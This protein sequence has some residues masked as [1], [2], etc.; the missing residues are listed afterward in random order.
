MPNSR[1][2]INAGVWHLGV[3]LVLL[4][5]GHC[6]AAVIHAAGMDDPKGQAVWLSA[7][8]WLT[9]TWLL[10]LIPDGSGARSYE[11]WRLQT[12]VQF[13][14]AFASTTIILLMGGALPQRIWAFGQRSAILVGLILGLLLGGFW[15]LVTSE[16][17]PMLLLLA[18]LGAI[19]SGVMHARCFGCRLCV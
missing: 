9:P 12:L 10:D 16:Q 17:N 14:V 13:P 19:A 1:N 6:I 7:P 11:T 4:Y 3:V 8:L 5:Y 15:Y 18:P 2:A